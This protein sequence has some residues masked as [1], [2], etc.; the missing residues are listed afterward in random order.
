M[1]VGDSE[2]DND[3]SKSDESEGEN[4]NEEA[5]Y[6]LVNSQKNIVK[7]LKGDVDVDTD[8]P[9]YGFSIKYAIMHQFITDY[10]FQWRWQYE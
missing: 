8:T 7:F 9:K 3:I 1:T 10:D 6:A 5:E 2:S 4:G